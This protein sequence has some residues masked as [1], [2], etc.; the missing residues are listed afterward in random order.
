MLFAKGS[1]LIVGVVEQPSTFTVNTTAAGHGPL[2]MSIRSPT[3]PDQLQLTYVEL[4]EGI[5]LSYIPRIAGK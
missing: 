5:E 2:L 4:D 1:G 3:P